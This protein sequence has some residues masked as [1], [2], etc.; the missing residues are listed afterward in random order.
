MTTSVITSSIIIYQVTSDKICLRLARVYYTNP[1][2]TRFCFSHNA[3]PPKPQ[4]LATAGVL[5][6]VIAPG[7]PFSLTAL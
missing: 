6:A 1:I 7:G 4:C 3:V 2:K 5:L